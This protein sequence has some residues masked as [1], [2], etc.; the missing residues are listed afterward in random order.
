MFEMYLLICS[1]DGELSEE[2]FTNE[3]RKLFPK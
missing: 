2:E 1:P 3:L